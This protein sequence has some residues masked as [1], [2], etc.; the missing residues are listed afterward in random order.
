MTI[1]SGD[2]DKLKGT[3]TR[4]AA[5]GARPA[6]RRQP[7]RGTV[8]GEDGSIRYGLFAIKGVGTRAA[9]AIAAERQRVGP[10]SSVDD[11]CVRLDQTLLNKGSLEAMTKAGAFDSLGAVAADFDELERSLRSLAGARKDRARGQAR[12]SGPW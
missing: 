3:S 11:L 1:E 10:Y 5:A 12:C 6:A 8:L 7:Q 2:T 9:E 4:P